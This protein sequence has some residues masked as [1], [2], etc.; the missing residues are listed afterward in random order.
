MRGSFRDTPKIIFRMGRVKTIDK[1]VARSFNIFHCATSVTSLSPPTRA[2]QRFALYVQAVHCDVAAA[3]R[4]EQ[5][6]N[7]LS[8][9]TAQRRDRACFLDLEAVIRKPEVKNEGH[10]AHA[11]GTPARL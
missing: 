2:L 10:C 8:E 7:A 3:L 11:D 6:H 1:F 4:H 5:F 9:L